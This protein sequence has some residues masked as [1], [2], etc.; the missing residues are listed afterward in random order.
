MDYQLFDESSGQHAANYE[1]PSL[2]GNYSKSKLSDVY[3]S[4]TN[5]NAVQEAIRYQVYVR[6]GNK[7]II[8]RQSETEL[9]IVMRSVYLEHSKNLPFDIIGQV[10]EL[11]AM[12]INYSVNDILTEINLRKQYLVDINT[13]PMPL[14]RSLNVSTA[15][16]KTLFLR[17]L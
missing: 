7:H 2:Y 8:G 6:S 13:Q 10:K 14:P 11:N 4:R 3:F 12:V 17:E 1:K 15:G 16:T 5:M 9:A